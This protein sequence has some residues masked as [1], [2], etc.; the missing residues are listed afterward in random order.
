MAKLRVKKRSVVL[1]PYTYQGHVTPMLQLGKILHSKGFSVIVAHPDFN[2]P[3]PSN[4][5]EFVFL[6]LEANLS[7][8]D[9]SNDILGVMSAM[10]Q[11]CK[12]PLVDYLVPMIKDQE[13]Y[14]QISCII[15]DILMGFGNSVAVQLKIP[16]LVL[17]T[18]SAFYMQTYRIVLKLQAQNQ[19]PLREAKMLEPVPELHA[20]RYKDL[21]APVNVK[22]DDVVMDFF[23]AMAN[24]GSS[25]GIIWNT[26]EGLDRFA[27]EEFRQSYKV[28]S[29]PVGPF[30]KMKGGSSCKSLDD[31]TEFIC[32]FPLIN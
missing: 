30:H 24:I 6:P 25:V 22:I 23:T 12:A 19:I 26:E 28:P 18:C 14:G 3:N 4:H 5:P 29:F 27:L 10:N 2:S 13:K 32:S 11:S 16:S 9:T 1:I 17:S 8:L 20:L 31:L 7:G 21:V 15:Y